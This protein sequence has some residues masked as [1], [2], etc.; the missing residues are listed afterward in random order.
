[1][2]AK[3]RVAV[4]FGGRSAEHEVSLQSARNVIDAIDKDRYKTVLIGIDRQGAWYL[5]D[6]SIPL[7]NS[8][9]PQL[10]VLNKSSEP[11]SLIASDKSG[12]LIN[13]QRPSS[14]QAI[15]VLFPVLHGPYGE[16]GSVQGL[17][18]LANV[19]CVGSDILG[20][21]IGMDKDISKRLLR[22]AGIPVARYVSFRANSLPEQLIAQ[23]EQAFGFP[24][25][26][27]PANMG[28]SVGV[29]KVSKATDLNDAVKNALQYDSK[30]LIE[31][32]IS[33]RELECAVL[34]NDNPIASD[35]GEIVTE[36][37]FYSYEKKYIDENAALLKIPAE[38]DDSTREQIRTMSIAV[39]RTLEVRGM[40]RIDMFLAKDG[41]LYVNEINTIPGF[42]SISMYPKLWQASGISYKELIDRIISLAI[43]EHQSKS[44]LISTGY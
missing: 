35:V 6:L 31:E 40:A 13:P 29:V 23:V 26:V 11:V 5:N 3:I 20:S 1:M 38:L 21:A 2:K 43:E 28:S 25:Y 17:A 36:D 42:T 19:P 22:D 33:G 27:K 7:L 30:I 10:S 9:N 34:G 18:K 41:G 8:N 37:G 4:L 14:M 15:D 44:Q 24:V 39:F 32:E 12:V 16:D